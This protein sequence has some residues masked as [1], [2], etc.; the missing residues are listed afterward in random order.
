MTKRKTDD[1]PT[2]GALTEVA[3]DFI[4]SMPI[5]AFLIDE[6]KNTYLANQAMAEAFGYES[7]EALEKRIRQPGF[8]AG[9][10]QPEA[11]AQLYETLLKREQVEGWQIN[12]ISVDGRE[13]NFEAKFRGRL[14]SPQGPPCYL[15]AVFLAAGRPMDAELFLAEARKEAELASKAKTEFLSNISHELRT[16]LH[17]I[18]GMLGLTVDDNSISENVRH[19]LA[20]AKE[21]ADGL[22]VFINDLIMLSD[23][24]AGRLASDISP[25]SPALLL[26]SL[27]QRFSAQAAGKNIRLTVSED[28][29]SSEIV[30]AGYNL[31]QLAMAKL[32]DNAIKFTE[33]GGEVSISAKLESSG[34]GLGL[35]CRVVDNGPG[36]AAGILESRALFVQGDG[37]KSRRHSGLG[38]GFSITSNIFSILGS[39]LHHAVPPGGGADLSFLVPVK[40]H[41]TDG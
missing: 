32:V 17:I 34:G 9:H 15:S 20:M 23:L 18:I 29:K 16:P 33:A 40:Q 31:I 35:L 39:R 38:L 2:T 13:L 21:A 3:L 36:I 26:N 27:A 5:P 1:Q 4:R 6:E 19:N 37:S 41:E 12:G 7:I 11:V 22:A 30:E 10:F 24:E 14:R 8:L 28:D 25:F